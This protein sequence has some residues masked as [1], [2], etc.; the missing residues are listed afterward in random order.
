MMTPVMHSEVLDALG[1]EIVAGGHA[2]GTA[3]TLSRLED[4][5]SMS[6]TVIRE[7]MRVLESL[8]LVVSRR[9]VGVVVQP[10][11][12]WAVLAPRVIAWRL[13]S[14]ARDAQLRSLTQLRQA[15]EPS[16]ARAAA[17]RGGGELAPRMLRMARVMR[18]LG[19]RGE[20]ASEEYLKADVAFHTLL[21]DASGNELF[22]ALGPTISEVLRGRMRVG[23]TPAWPT[24]HSLANHEEIALAIMQERAEDAERLA[25][26]VVGDVL[27]EIDHPDERPEGLAGPR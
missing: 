12:G 16:A 9:G 23:D 8:G 25:R 24:P 21:L 1:R 27:R 15:I 7:A 4:R 13:A 22:A 2:P 5:F 20:G 6:R 17:V 10:M 18:E 19:L 11:S 14:G 3:L 26:T